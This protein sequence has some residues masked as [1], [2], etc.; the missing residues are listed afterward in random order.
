[1]ELHQ[2]LPSGQDTARTRWGTHSSGAAFDRKKTPYLTEDAQQFL[3]EQAVCVLAGLGP[4]HQLVGMLALGTPGFVQA[5]DKHT[6]LVRLEANLAT[7]RLVLGMRQAQSMNQV[8]HLGLFCICHASRKRLC[9][10]GTAELLAQPPLAS[11]GPLH[12]VLWQRLQQLILGRKPLPPSKPAQ[13]VLSVRVQVT[14]AFFHCPKYI[15]TS[16]PGLT[17]PVE[18]E[19]KR[20]WQVSDVLG[21]GHSALSE[22]VRA[23]LAEQVL[24]YL[25][26]VDQSGRCAVNHRGGAPGFLVSLSPHTSAPGGLILLPDYAGNGAFEALGNILETGQAAV[27]VPNYASQVALCIS[28]VAHILELAELRPEVAEQCI[29]AERVVA[30]LVQR[31][32]FQHGDWTLALTHAQ[33]QAKMV[34]ETRK[35]AAVCPTFSL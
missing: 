16:I 4:D 23:F 20:M 6:C 8:T 21:S 30:L 33:A 15:K 1:M 9:V 31:V 3:T 14:R 13:P 27:V 25:C 2:S 24:C 26:T 32:E 17:V 18:V 19:P 10:Q 28:G 5:L 35:L 12:H 7:S 22:A 29:G 34:L 11:P